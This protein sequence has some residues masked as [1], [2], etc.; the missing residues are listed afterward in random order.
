M[1][2]NTKHTTNVVP[3]ALSEQHIISWNLRG[4]R[5]RRP[6]LNLLMSKYNTIAL[7]LQET[8]CLT[9]NQAIIR[10]YTIYHRPRTDG[11]RASGGVITAIQSEVDS[12]RIDLNT[13]LEAVAVQVGAPLNANIL[14]VYLPPGGHITKE[15]IKKLI[16][17][18]PEPFLLVGDINAHHPLW[19]SG[20]TSAR[21][22]LI[23]SI[24]SEEN[25][26][27]MNNGETT[28]INNATGLGSCIDICC[29]TRH[30]AGTID[31][32]V[33]D[34]AYGSD[35]IPLIVS[36][37]SPLQQ[38]QSSP[39]WKTE[40]ADWEKYQRIIEIATKDDAIEQIEEITKGITVAA[41]QSIPKTKGTINGKQVPWWNEKVS[42]A[43]KT[44]R[45]ALRRLKNNITGSSTPQLA[46][47]YQEANT[48]AQEVINEAKNKSWKEFTKKFNVHTSVKEMW[49]NY[50]KI[51][52]KY[53]SSSIREIRQGD[54]RMNTDS[55]I[56]NSLANHFA[57]IS[58]NQGYTQ[59]FNLF[60]NKV[61]QTPL[62]IPQADGAEYNEPFTKREFEEATEG[63]K[64]SSP[65]PD[66][67]NY[68][69]IFNLPIEYKNLLLDTYNRLW[70]DSIYPECWTRSIVVPIYKGKGER[71]CPGNYRPIYLNSCL[72]KVMERMINNRL[73]FIIEERK[74][75]NQHQYA[76]RKG[77]STADYLGHL[78]TTVREAT[79][80]KLLAQAVFLDIKK[81]YDTTWRRLILNRIKEW[82]IGGNLLRYI[83][84]MLEK[85]TF[86]VKANGTLSQE[87]VMENGLCQGS[88]IS[89][90]LFLIAIDTICSELP[91][92]VQV[93]LY[94]DD[95]VL[96]SSDSNRKNLAKKLQL[97]LKAIEEWENRTGF[98][99]ST[100]KSA[101]V[102][103]KNP[104]MKKQPN[105][106]LKLNNEIIPEKSHNKCLG[107]TL[108]QHLTYKAHIEETKA[109]CNQRIQFLKCIA[110]RVWG[111][112]K[113]T[114]TKIYKST[115]LE[116]M[117]YAAPLISLSSETLINQLEST[118]NQG[119]R[120]IT[121][122][123]HT[124]PITSLQTEAG[125]PSF[126]SL[127]DQRMLI[128][129][130]KPTNNLQ[131]PVNSETEE[132]SS[133]SSGELWNQRPI[134]EPDTIITRSRNLLENLGAPLPPGKVLSTPSSAPWKRKPILIDKKLH[135]ASR[136]GQNHF[137]L[138]KLFAERIHTKYRLHET[139][140]TDGSKNDS[141]SGFSVITEAEIIRKRTHNHLTIY[142]VE[143]LAIIE[144]L[145][146][147]M[148]QG[149]IGA[150]I[151]CTDS[152]SVITTLEKKK[153]KS[154]LKDEIISLYNEITDQ[155]TSVTFCWVPSHI[156]IPGNEKADRE[157]KRA[158]DNNNIMQKVVDHQEVK[159]IIK[160][161][162][163]NKWQSEWC[164]T[165]N[166][167]L[168]EIRNSIT[169][170]KE[171][172]FENR[173]EDV[174]LTRLRIGHTQLT[175]SYL[176]EKTDPP[177]C[178]KC[179][180]LLTIKHIIVD[181]IGY[182]D[183]REKV[184]LTPNMREA[185]AD[186][187]TRAKKVLKFFKEIGLI[188]AV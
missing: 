73:M 59:E 121:G 31:F 163:K 28:Y 27:V 57:R 116:K 180:Q 11:S 30:L 173:R 112:D 17:Q 5:T 178:D 19:G 81:A 9:D 107:V 42:T 51:Q 12:K 119:L 172:V 13:N 97:A 156:G 153:I 168:R 127:L 115:V 52:G 54:Q 182:D 37:P 79:N 72:G 23:E 8:M 134:A 169:P 69:M 76:F 120:L 148:N 93:L 132:E 174:I 143:S 18:V 88:V 128:F 41:E 35:H 131:T 63:L 170:F 145:T 188:D 1:S 36:V 71:T 96:I 142:S 110:S 117:L 82:N 99:I 64:G 111:G 165:R 183:A 177:K 150:Y 55:D 157:A 160:T 60:K 83:Q 155:G 66:N 159:T 103:F 125:I 175:H 21:G 122:A 74:L 144:A 176:L 161:T 2:A 7:C 146:W 179:N 4:L 149:R 62:T 39:R 29:C 78:D 86:R 94:A 68:A 108:D 40:E 101:T 118:H 48:K 185:L 129:A 91:Q 33:A 152:L 75:I 46:K 77:K 58:S 114:L 171:A 137:Q 109:A 22:R 130:T 100:E 126:R 89:V 49:K 67:I 105:V 53:R 20:E 162:M 10:G 32:T 135:Y 184:G 147:I 15:E 85:R 61:E 106:K 154:I 181:C 90:T 136:N 151:I 133:N 3:K 84:Q 6:D 26:I 187:S 158:L 102:V 47:E 104:R 139:I 80:K 123:F 92:G 14:N 138:R 65:G 25:L 98:K 166:N 50:R 87:T 38:S 45:K 70:K 16:S 56:A 124:S 24:T 167:K 34:D 113:Q 95:V 43:V 141:K 186:D 44:R 140:F 164:A